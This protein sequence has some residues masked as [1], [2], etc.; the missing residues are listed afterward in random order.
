VLITFETNKRNTNVV[1]ISNE[2]D[3]YYTPNTQKR[4][5]NNILN[6]LEQIE[7]NAFSARQKAFLEHHQSLLKQITG[8][9]P[10]GFYL[11]F[12]SS[13]CQPC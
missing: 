7:K 2:K 12:R 8:T 5:V 4:F 3:I 6:Q 1:H 13:K 9:F 11:L 10:I